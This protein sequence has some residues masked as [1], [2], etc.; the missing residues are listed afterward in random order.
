M[1]KIG[2]FD[3]FCRQIVLPEEYVEFKRWLTEEKG[4]SLEDIPRT[5]IRDL[6]YEWLEIAVE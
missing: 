1:T 4:L 3:A 2:D 5:L 6:Y